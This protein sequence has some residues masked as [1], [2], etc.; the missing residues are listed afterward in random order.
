MISPV[1]RSAS[2]APRRKVSVGPVDLDQGVADR[3]AGL[4]AMSRPSSSRR[5]LMPGADL[6]QDPAALVGGQRSG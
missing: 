4:E 1:I 6:A 5:A 2:S 3:L